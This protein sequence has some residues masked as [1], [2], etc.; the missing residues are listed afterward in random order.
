VAI[1]KDLIDSA[2]DK[3]ERKRMCGEISVEL[4]TPP[5]FRQ[6][7]NYDKDKKEQMFE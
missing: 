6:I 7:D 2:L 1:D 4:P 5:L 3:F